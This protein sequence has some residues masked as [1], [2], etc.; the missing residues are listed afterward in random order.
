MS[1]EYSACQLRGA[2][3][4]P[5]EYQPGN[6]CIVNAKLQHFKKVAS[7]ILVAL[8]IVFIAYIGIRN[9]KDLTL[10]FSEFDQFLFALSV[11][12]G[13]LG[14]LGIALLF[15]S[16]LVKHNAL[17]SAQDAAS[18]FYLS[19]ITKYVPGK[20]WGILYQASRVEGMTGSIAILLSNIELMG[21]A[22]FTNIVI[23]TSILSASTY[24]AVSW[25]TLI[26]GIGITYY[27]T[28]ANALRF[29]RKYLNKKFDTKSLDVIT[30]SE[31]VLF[32][33]FAYWVCAGLFVIANFALLSAFFD[34]DTI[35]KLH[36]IAY[37][38]L[39]SAISVLVVVMPAG[40]GVKEVI[41]LLL[42]GG[43]TEYY[44]G[45]LVTV[46]IVSRFWQ[47]TMD[48]SGAALVFALRR[49]FGKS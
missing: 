35:S 13:V 26:F 3:N 10:V 27:V 45:L 31:N 19:Q 22:I 41:F 12:A 17:I 43:S 32:D 30:H 37:L 40:I 33:L 29:V 44:E 28:K 20:I 9:W 6:C 39:A 46:A 1:K 36:L 16:L 34:L 2:T 4:R 23:A 38:L 25:V 5:N 8:G 47:V 15:R 11:A 14:N 18:L 7:N 21:I 24:P 49:F 42:A 48:L